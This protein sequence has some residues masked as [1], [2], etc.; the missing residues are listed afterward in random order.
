MLATQAELI[1]HIA[2]AYGRD[3][4]DPER[5]P[6][7]VALIEPGGT[8]ALLAGRV[9]GRLLPGAG[10]LVGLLAAGGA[11]DRVARRAIAHY[12]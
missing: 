9:A 12:R 6:E 1:L 3:P 5:V 7:L 10:L 2:A 4:C 11:M 8:G